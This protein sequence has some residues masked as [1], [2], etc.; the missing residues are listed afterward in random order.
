MRKKYA[1]NAQNAML[2]KENMIAIMTIHKIK[3]LKTFSEKETGYEKKN[4]CIDDGGGYG[5]FNDC[6]WKSSERNGSEGN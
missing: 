3:M 1:K 2:T 4:R 6:L 5:I